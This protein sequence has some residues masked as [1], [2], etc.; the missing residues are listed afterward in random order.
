MCFLFLLP[1]HVVSELRVLVQTL[2]QEVLVSK[3]RPWFQKRV[4]DSG[5]MGQQWDFI[6]GSCLSQKAL[7]GF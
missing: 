1:A 6:T 4:K 7:H 2:M 3:A 5:T